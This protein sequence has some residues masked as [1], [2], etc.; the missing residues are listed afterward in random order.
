MKDELNAIPGISATRDGDV[1][2][3]SVDL[4]RRPQNSSSKGVFSRL[5]LTIA[6]VI[7]AVACAWAWQLQL[8]ID[9]YTLMLERYSTR[10]GDLEDLLSDTD[11]TVN[12]SAAAMRGQLK[13][14]DIE[15]RKLWDARK[16][17]NRKISELEKKSKTQAN[18]IGGLASAATK[19]DAQLTEIQLEISGFSALAKDLT[20]LAAS[21]KQNQTELE[22][23]ADGV[24]RI[25][26]EQ[27]KL[28]KRVDENEGWV[29]S[30]NAWRPQ[31]NGKITQ[32]ETTIRES[33]N[34][35][36]QTISD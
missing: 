18:E 35:E 10:I 22:R 13:R 17:S 19:S 16:V 1:G 8:E 14:L 32:L 5:L 31:V 4:P 7:A 23:V 27:A 12:Q 24:N 36:V 34:I 25:D 9:K 28:V 6:F 3:P 29:E 21:A 20:N 15:N 26:L 30:I 11:E 33:N 2:I